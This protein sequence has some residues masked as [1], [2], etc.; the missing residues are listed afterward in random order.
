MPERKDNEWI[1]ELINYARSALARTLQDALGFR[2][3]GSDGT[4]PTDPP[5]SYVSPSEAI[6]DALTRGVHTGDIGVASAILALASEVGAATERD[7]TWLK[8]YLAALPECTRIA[9]RC[10]QPEQT[11][12][13]DFLI[14]DPMV[15]AAVTQVAC[16]LAEQIADLSVKK[17]EV[18]ND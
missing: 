1:L 15:L 13:S 10:I 9:A 14:V 3:P 6:G 16:D 8:T 17:G 12:D 5:A 18:E 2:L 7:S 11:V 4:F